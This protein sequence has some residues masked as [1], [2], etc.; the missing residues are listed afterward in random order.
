MA[1]AAVPAA[2]ATAAIFTALAVGVL[3]GVLNGTF[4]AYLR[5]QPFVAT[6]AMLT[7]ARGIAFII[8]GGRSIGNLPDSYG[9]LGRAVPI[10]IPA[11]V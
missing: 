1:A 6:L 11:P 5:V 9:A 3:T 7:I 4:V 10:G 8:S 2:P